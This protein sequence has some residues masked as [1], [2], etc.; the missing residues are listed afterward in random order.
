[1]KLIHCADVHLGARLESKFPQEVS[2]TRKE[3]V[4]NSFKRMV[5]YAVENG[6]Q[7]ILLA[8]DIF[9]GE[10]PTTKDKEF[11]Y[12]VVQNNPNIT[13]LYLR[14]NHDET[15][16]NGGF[17]NLKTFSSTWTG[18]DFG[19]VV[20]SGIEIVKENATSLYST[21]SLDESRKNI[22]MMHGQISDTAGV[23]KVCLK[24][25]RN[26]NVDYFA[27]GHIH[28]YSYGKLDER[29]SYAY[30]GCLEGRGFDETGEKGFI[31]VEVEESGITHQ[32]V[33]FSK[34]SILKAQVDVSG[35]AG[36]YE[37][38]LKAR[39]KGLDKQNIYRIELVGEVDANVDAFASDVKKF[40]SSECL[41]VDVKDYTQ[42]KI[43]LHAYD[44]DLSLRGEFVR[45]VYADNT[46]TDEEK[47][48]I[49]AYGLKALGGR[50]VE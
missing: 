16:E 35:L 8:G 42:K 17:D 19:D 18:Y 40:L 31:L 27:L 36:G 49:V 21:L 50:E 32:F 34:R 3:E 26:K 9:D 2:K 48:Q 13:F 11:F 28:E 14:G 1:M 47:A 25:L 7:V 44:N 12:S 33:P 37:M 38:A 30:S 41:F 10:R 39:E 22:V 23:D 6:V 46:L 29:G 20:I 15:E 45:E 24:K 43:N 5:E 4:R